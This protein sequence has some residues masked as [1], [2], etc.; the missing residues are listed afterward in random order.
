VTLDEIARRVGVSR[1]T[2]SNAYNRPDQ[3]SAALRERIME[4]ARELGYAGPDPAARSLRT[5]VTASI[6]V[7]L[8]ETL[9]YAF[10]DSAAI[11]FLNGL[12][13]RVE[14]QGLSILLVPASPR[15]DAAA[16][17]DAI[18]DGFVVYSMPAE[19]PHVEAI[20]SRGQP[21]VFVDQPRIPH[22]HFV[23]V[24]I[25]A[26]SR[27]LAE[28]LLALGHRR[29]A[30]VSFPLGADVNR[31]PADAARQAA[32]TR[33][34]TRDRLAGYRDAVEAAGLDWEAIR[35]E[36]R[37]R[38]DEEEGRDAAMVLLAQRPRPTAI[39]A[40]SDHLSLGVIEACRQLGLRVPDDVSVVGFDD[41]PQ[42]SMSDP[43]LTTMRQPLT[44]KGD[45]AGELLLASLAGTGG[46]PRA[47][48]LGTELVRRGS[49][50]PPGIGASEVMG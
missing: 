2:V 32:A 3:L 35:V 37:L 50:A 46:P 43:P 24:D 21:V 16:V 29:L 15:R 7:A 47:H 20:L 36:E 41:I 40:M 31:G 28:H 9:S 44:G 27:Q 42:A 34:V 25:R 8:T 17:R 38:S 26:A 19:D 18:V 33:E 39:L 11:G 48:I 4:T 1:A 12:T 23:G 10:S 6:G 5:G 45:L 30:V 13:R 49:T 14:A 22:A